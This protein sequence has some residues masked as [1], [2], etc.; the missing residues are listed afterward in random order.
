MSD[1]SSTL[2]ALERNFYDRDTATVARELIGMHL[3]RETRAG[4]VRGRIVETEAYL[5]REDSACHAAR[6]KTP[7]NASMFG[8]PGIA[9][10]YAIHSRWCFNVVTES[11]GVPAAVLIRAL[12]PLEGLSAMEERRGLTRM[13]DLARGPARL[14]EAFEIDRRLDGWDLTQQQRLWIA[15]AESDVKESPDIVV[16]RRIGVTSAQDLLLRFACREN[17]FVS[18]PKNWASR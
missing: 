1:L 4:R 5:P 12:E 17:S 6:G 10:V 13:L 11:R 8:K 15:R 16:T 7:R 14:C 18:G 3:I 2:V 9:Y